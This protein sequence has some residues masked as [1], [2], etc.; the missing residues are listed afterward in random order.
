MTIDQ[1]TAATNALDK[2]A[3]GAFD[4][5]MAT[6]YQFAACNG[7]AIDES[8]PDDPALNAICTAWGIA[9]PTL[10][11]P[12]DPMPPRGW[13]DWLWEQIRDLPI[14]IVGP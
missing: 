1:L 4:C 11:G 14:L 9:K 13:I 5:F 12:F 10:P 2:M 8:N 6:V 7:F 3:P